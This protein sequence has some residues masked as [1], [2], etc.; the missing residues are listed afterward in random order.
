MDILSKSKIKSAID[1]MYNA[2]SNKNPR[3]VGHAGEETCLAT[4]E[5]E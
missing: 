3:K 4:Q 1:N 5:E 2:E